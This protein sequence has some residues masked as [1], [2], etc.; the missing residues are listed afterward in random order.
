MAKERLRGTETKATVAAALKFPPNRYHSGWERE[1]ETNCA[2]S[3][4]DVGES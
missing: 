3:L 4:S 2:H 1:V